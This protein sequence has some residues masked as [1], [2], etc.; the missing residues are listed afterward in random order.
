MNKI[1]KIANILLLYAKVYVSLMRYTYGV[2]GWGSLMGFT[3][4]VQS[5]CVNNLEFITDLL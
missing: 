5:Q 1:R 2:H 3:D 4:G